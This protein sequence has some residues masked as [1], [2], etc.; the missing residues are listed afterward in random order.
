MKFDSDEALLDHYNSELLD[1]YKQREEARGQI[2]Q[3][4]QT[5]AQCQQVAQIA[6]RNIERTNGAEVQLKALIKTVDPA[7]KGPSDAQFNSVTPSL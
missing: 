3:A 1:C 5:I 2:T 4:Q 6:E 7:V